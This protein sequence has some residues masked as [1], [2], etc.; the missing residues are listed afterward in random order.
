MFFYSTCFAAVQSMGW[1]QSGT[2]PGWDVIQTAR[3]TG[4]AG[5]C[6]DCPTIYKWGQSLSTPCYQTVRKSG[7]WLHKLMEVCVYSVGTFK[8]NI[9]HLFCLQPALYELI[10]ERRIGFHVKCNKSKCWSS[11]NNFFMVWTLKIQSNFG[12]FI[13]EMRTRIISL[14]F[15]W[16]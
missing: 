15:L 4:R 12:C 5:W 11:W 7:I 8:K 1:C 3:G 14:T 6:P 2:V 10:P 9:F 13:L 16:G